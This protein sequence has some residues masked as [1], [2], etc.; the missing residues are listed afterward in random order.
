MSTLEDLRKFYTYF[1]FYNISTIINNAVKTLQGVH[2]PGGGGG[3]VHSLICN[4]SRS[5]NHRIY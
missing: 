4:T 1:C 2:H 3:G 5:V